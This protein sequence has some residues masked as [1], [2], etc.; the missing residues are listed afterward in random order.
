MRQGMKAGVVQPR[1]LME[2]VLPQLDAVIKPTAEESIFWS[3]IRTMPNTIAAEDKARISAEYKRMIELRI[4]PAY[5]ALR[6]F[7]AT[8]YLPATRASSGLGAL[9]DGQAWNCRP[10]SPR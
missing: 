8:E 6:G 7:I 5:R 10:R 2:K 4:M 9:P 3:P 1:D